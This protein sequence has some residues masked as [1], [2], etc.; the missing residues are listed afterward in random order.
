[1]N[2]TWKT[3]ARMGFRVFEVLLAVALLAVLLELLLVMLNAPGPVPEIRILRSSSAPEV[4]PAVVLAP[5][6]LPPAPVPVAVVPPVVPPPAPRKPQPPVLLDFENLRRLL[7]VAKSPPSG[8]NPPNISGGHGEPSGGAA[9]SSPGYPLLVIAPVLIP[10]TNGV[11][12]TNAPTP[13]ATNDAPVTQRP[14]ETNQ[15]TVASAN[16]STNDPNVFR[17]SVP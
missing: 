5:A 7:G 13:P 2:D 11:P 4:A 6:E 3:R 17:F 15:T 10:P 16:T 1:M 8:N 14:P 9:G 12:V